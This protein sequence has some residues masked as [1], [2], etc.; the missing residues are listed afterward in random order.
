MG[1]PVCTCTDWYGCHSSSY[2]LSN[3]H[4]YPNENWITRGEKN[5]NKKQL[6]THTCLST[7]TKHTIPTL[8]HFRTVF[9]GHLQ[10]RQEVPRS[11]LILVLFFCKDLMM[12]SM[13]LTT[14]SKRYSY[15]KKKLHL[16]YC[17]YLIF[18]SHPSLSIKKEEKGEKK[19]NWASFFL[20]S[21]SWCHG[22]CSGLRYEQ[23]RQTQKQ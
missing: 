22:Y 17:P 12:A 4:E 14:K 7:L 2:W 18:V 5:K 3:W 21:N 8:A 9:R 23:E 16:L 13:I 20:E 6:P 1:V 10:H 19:K 11:L 15:Y